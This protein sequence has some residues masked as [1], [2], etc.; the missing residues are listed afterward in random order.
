MRKHNNNI[1]VGNTPDVLTD[2]GTIVPYLCHKQ[3]LTEFIVA[4]LTV[5]LALMTSRNATQATRLLYSGM[6]THNLKHPF[7]II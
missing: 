4:D 7:T 6:V 2:A 3:E 1:R 5:M